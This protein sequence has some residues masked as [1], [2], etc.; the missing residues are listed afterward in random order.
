[1][2]LVLLIHLIKSRGGLNDGGAYGIPASTA[3]FSLFIIPLLEIAIKSFAL[4]S[5]P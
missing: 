4:A 1:M 5:I 3:F 2:D